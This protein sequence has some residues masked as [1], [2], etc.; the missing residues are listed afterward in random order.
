MSPLGVE[1]VSLF[2]RAMLES[3]PEMDLWAKDGDNGFGRL[4]RISGLFQTKRKFPEMLPILRMIYGTSSKAWYMGLQD[5]IE[6]ID[7]SEGC[8]QGDVLSMWFYAMAIHPFLQKI[9]D[10]LGNEGF[11]KWYADDGNTI[12]PFNKMVEVL[13]IVKEFFK[14]V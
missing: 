13:Q 7:S 4:S 14:V 3:N 2:I 10:V 1:S 5:G 9:R 8:Q 11:T 6:A 12:A